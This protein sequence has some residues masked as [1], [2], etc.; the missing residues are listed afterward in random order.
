MGRSSSS[1]KSSNTTKNVNIVNNNTGRGDDGGG[2]GSALADS[3]NLVESEMTVGDITTTDYGAVEKGAQVSAKA[4]DA[5]TQVVS[6]L[7][8]LAYDDVGDARE[9]TGIVAGDAMDQFQ[10]TTE[11]ALQRTAENVK[12]AFSFAQ[13]SE[14]SDS[15]LALESITPW[16]FGAVIVLALVLL[17]RSNA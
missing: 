12:Q 17:W 2:T 4:L 7:A 8:N 5:N 15:S 16:A 3:L 11:M 1:S 10:R 13:D 9:W 14:R 6:E